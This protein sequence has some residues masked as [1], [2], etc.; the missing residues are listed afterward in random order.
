MAPSPVPKE[1][2]LLRWLLLCLHVS[3][4]SSNLLGVYGVYGSNRVRH[5]LDD[6]DA[7]LGMN[8][9]NKKDKKDKRKGMEWRTEG[10]AGIESRGDDAEGETREFS[11]AE[12]RRSSLLSRGYFSRWLWS[13]NKNDEDN[14]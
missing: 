14:E 1:L 8:K 10:E 6:I 13:G 12:S 2:R 11:A 3:V 7:A 9:K 4:L 5:R